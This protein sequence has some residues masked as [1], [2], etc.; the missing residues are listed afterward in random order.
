MVI[1][2]TEGEC[3]CETVRPD[4]ELICFA[5]ELEP[6]P[7]ERLQ[8][9]NHCRQGITSLYKAETYTV[10]P[11]RAP[12]LLSDMAWN[13]ALQLAQPM[14]GPDVNRVAVLYSSPNDRQRQWLAIIADARWRKASASPVLPDPRFL[15]L[16]ACLVAAIELQSLLDANNPSAG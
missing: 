9:N 8:G 13:H 4:E 2:K 10:P 15:D 7:T 14:T 12:L 3:L 11:E 5:G 16:S 6:W 1:F